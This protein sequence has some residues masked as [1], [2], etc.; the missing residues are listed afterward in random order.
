[1]DDSR[2]TPS[3]SELARLHYALVY[4]YA[5]RLCGSAEEAETASA[6]IWEIFDVQP[7][8]ADRPGDP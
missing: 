1:M 8:I 6:R 7:S 2:S 5:Y 4:R 3:L